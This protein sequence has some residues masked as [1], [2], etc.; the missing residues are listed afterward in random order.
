[1]NF[2]KFL[3]L[4]F[5]VGLSFSGY[6][7]IRFSET[8]QVSKSA[9]D[10]KASLFFIDF[11]ATWCGPCV[12][13]SEYLGVLQK[14]YPDRFYVISLSEENPEVVKRFLKR[15]PTDLAI[16]I[17]YKGETFRDNNIRILPYGLLIDANGKILWKGSPT[18]F[19]KSDLE[20]F[21]RQNVKQKSIDKVFKVQEIKEQTAK[22]DYIPTSDFE[23]KSLKNETYET[24]VRRVKGEYVHYKGDLKSII[25]REYKILNSQ[26]NLTPELNRT[27]EVYIKKGTNA[28]FQILEELKLDLFHTEATGDVLMLDLSNIKYWDVHQIDW[29]KHTAKYLIDDTQIQADNV[30]FNDVMFQLA[31]VLDL[32]I[33]T[34]GANADELNHDWQIHHRFYNLMQS[35]MEDTY[36]IKVNKEK[37]NYK[38]YTIRKKTP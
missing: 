1:M 26:I 18:D 27:Y 9:T 37:G 14:Q 29:G 12:Y 13:A 30:T 36:G 8:I 3:L 24:L 5:C 10:T 33:V 15:K 6:S 23:I 4:L 7:Q 34:K 16:S 2:N 19:K 38:V 20:R 25:A 35:D 21:L 28:T 11:W 32:P 17:D 31:S 22:A